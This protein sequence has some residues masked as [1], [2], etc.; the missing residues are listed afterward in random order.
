VVVVVVVVVSMGVMM[1][2]MVPDVPLND[3]PESLAQLIGKLGSLAG[4]GLLVLAVGDTD[5][6]IA[7]IVELNGNVNHDSGLLS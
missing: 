4:V 3:R 6:G 5:N 7:I 1:V 2:V